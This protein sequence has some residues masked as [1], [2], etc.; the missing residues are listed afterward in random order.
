MNKL[1]TTAALLC[2]LSLG[3]TSCSKDDDKVEQV[4]QEYQAKVMVKDGE[5]VDLKKVSK[6]INTQ[7]T[8]KRT[9][10]IY[11]LRNFRQFTIGEDGKASTT[12]AETYYLDLKENDAA[13]TADVPLTLVAKQRDMDI[14]ANTLKSFSLSY[15]DKPFDQVSSTDQFISIADNKAGI[16]MSA[17]VIG[18]ANYDRNTHHVVAAKDRTLILLKDGRPYFKFKVNSA[19]SDEKPNKEIASDNYVFYSIDYQEFK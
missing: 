15:I 18:W 6:T 3:F 17:S 11:S 8:I 19:Y 5:T 4:E 2:A 1:F 13:N 12:A 10:K 14:S 7:G 16:S 9:G